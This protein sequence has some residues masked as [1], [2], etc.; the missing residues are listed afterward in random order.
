MTEVVLALGSNIGDRAGNL[1][2]G[3][4]LLQEYGIDILRV[5]SAWETPPVPADQPA[6]LNACAA[7]ETGMGPL[8]LLAVLKSCERQLGRRPA[9]HWGPRPLDLDIL[10]YGEERIDLPELTVPHPR[11]VERAF[12]LAPLAEVVRGPL[13]ILGLSAIDVLA[14]LPDGALVTR[15]AADLRVRTGPRL[16]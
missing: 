16:S 4:R 12:V 14:K 1:R 13:P 15:V 2:E 3:L 9:R 7:A 10:F 6:F 5:S 8:E 11:I